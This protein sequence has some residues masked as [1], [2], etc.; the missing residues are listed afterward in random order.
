MLGEMGHIRESLAQ[1]STNFGRPCASKPCRQGGIAHS[2]SPPP[3]L[4][5]RRV[6]Q[7]TPCALPAL[8]LVPGA[9]LALSFYPSALLLQNHVRCHPRKAEHY[10]ILR[11]NGSRPLKGPAQFMGSGWASR[12]Q[13]KARRLPGICSHRLAYGLPDANVGHSRPLA[14]VPACGQEW[15][16]VLPG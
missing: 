7:R 12:P 14:H 4:R 6:G 15:P 9:A 1:S 10:G 5:S 8:C 13:R 3:S 16:P 11:E 2:G